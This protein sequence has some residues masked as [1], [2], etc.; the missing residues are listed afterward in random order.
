LRSVKICCSL[1]WLLFS[2][3]MSREAFRLPMG[4]MRDPGA[5]FFPLMIALVTGLLALTALV[6]SLKVKKEKD[7]APATRSTE[8]FRWWNLAVI[9]V[10]LI[11]YALTLT[12]L[13]F[14]INT[15]LFMLV[16]LKVIEPQTWKKAILAAVI[17]A[18]TSDLFFNVLL[19]AQIPSG[20]LGF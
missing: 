6:Q 5:G 1:F 4:E 9:I 15:F 3:V 12:T 8:P 20:M 18:V 7:Q 14:M 13:G 2:V 11:A 17:T 19:Q 16:L 10:A